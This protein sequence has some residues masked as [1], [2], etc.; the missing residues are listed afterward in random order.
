MIVFSVSRLLAWESEEIAGV[1]AHHGRA[2]RCGCDHEAS[3]PAALRLII[4]PTCRTLG[5][6]SG[7]PGLARSFLD[8]ADPGIARSGSRFSPVAES[9]LLTAPP[10]TVGTTCHSLGSPLVPR[11][12]AQPYTPKTLALDED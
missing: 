10:D 12:L 9:S 3:T 4:V 11:L 8:G 7:G 2:S 1:S 5:V 6:K